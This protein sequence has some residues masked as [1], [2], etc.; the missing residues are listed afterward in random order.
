MATTSKDLSECT[1]CSP[2]LRERAASPVRSARQSFLTAYDWAWRVTHRILAWSWT[3]HMESESFPWVQRA[4]P[5]CKQA[6]WQMLRTK[7]K[8]KIC[9]ERSHSDLVQA[10][11]RYF[12]QVLDR[13][14][15]KAGTWQ[16]SLEITPRHKGLAQVQI[17]GLLK[18][19]L[20]RTA[21]NKTTRNSGPSLSAHQ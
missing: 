20:G 5:K 21:E 14:P 10:Q 12:P 17:Y 4:F 19:W 13:S 18:S 6:T 8:K 9:W 2:S 11:G 3:L 1:G 16:I 15:L 7:K